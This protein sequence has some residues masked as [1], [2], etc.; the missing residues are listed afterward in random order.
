MVYVV[1]IFLLQIDLIL[2]VPSFI[3][4]PPLTF[5]EKA[6]EEFEFY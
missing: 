2:D 5:H 1:S 4:M 6:K 3:A